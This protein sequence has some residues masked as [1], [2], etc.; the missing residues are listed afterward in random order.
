M[1]CVSRIM[2]VT[3]TLNLSNRAHV[4]P[5]SVQPQNL[6]TTKVLFFKTT[7]LSCTNFT[8]L[9]FYI[10][11]S[12]LHIHKQP[13]TL[14]IPKNRHP[15][16]L[17]ECKNMWHFSEK[18]RIKAFTKIKVKCPIFAFLVSFGFVF[19]SRLPFSRLYL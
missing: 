12:Y 6:G 17:S 3:F 8:S 1:T 15:I 2:S 14:V 5:L 18:W 10:F 11:S 16:L 19:S 4:V 7:F 9:Y 13:E